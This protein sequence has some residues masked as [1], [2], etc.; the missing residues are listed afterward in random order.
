M[1]GVTQLVNMA[2]GFKELTNEHNNEIIKW[3][4]KYS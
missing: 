2:W 1:L 4:D 3:L